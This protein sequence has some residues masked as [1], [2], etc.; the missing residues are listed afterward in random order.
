MATDDTETQLVRDL[1]QAA[2]EKDSP[3]LSA[4]TTDLSQAGAEKEGDP[5]SRSDNSSAEPLRSNGSDNRSSDGSS[6]TGPD[7]GGDLPDAPKENPR[8]KELLAQGYTD[9]LGSG[10][11][12][13]KTLSKGPDQETR[14]EQDD[15]VIML[16]SLSVNGDVLFEQQQE[17]FRVG[18]GDVCQA[19]DMV[20]RL[21]HVQDV[22]HVI[23]TARLDSRPECQSGE[24]EYTLQL[25]E[26]QPAEDIDMMPLADRLAEGKLK[27][28]IAKKWAG[29]FDH[30]AACRTLKRGLDYLKID[31]L[32]AD[33]VCKL[34]V[35]VGGGVFFSVSNE[36][37]FFLFFRQL[38]GQEATVDEIKK[39]QSAL[40][41][42]IAV[43]FTKTNQPRKALEASQK[44]IDQ[45][46]TNVKPYFLKM[47]AL[48]AM[49]DTEEAIACGQ[50]ALAVPSQDPNF[51]RD[52]KKLLREAREKEAQLREQEKRQAKRMMSALLQPPTTQ[53]PP[54]PVWW[55]RPL[56]VAAVV[57][58]LGVLVALWYGA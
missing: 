4:S 13:F 58:V 19:W 9:V 32:P 31:D 6:S 36:T 53:A 35:L 51:V 29:M 17:S 27:R 24:I 44:A 40:H 12:F 3:S 52:I 50:A 22:I 21:V 23:G 18:Q 10:A 47:K 37:I 11:L 55:K 26:I 42:N 38:E 5:P 46:S 7:D 8:T 33:A 20:V 16:A 1:Q 34:C 49:N 30:D 14:P 41:S 28:E 57:G 39:L 56:V 43:V 2:G 45:D 48:L 15:R 25:Q 54:P